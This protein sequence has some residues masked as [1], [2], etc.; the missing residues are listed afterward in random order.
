MIIDTLLLLG[1]IGLYTGLLKKIFTMDNKIQHI[2]ENCIHCN[3][4]SKK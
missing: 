1:L 4:K 3:D 2:K